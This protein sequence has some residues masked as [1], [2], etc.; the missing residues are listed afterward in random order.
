[1]KFRLTLGLSVIC[2]TAASASSQSI[3]KLRSAYSGKLVW[4]ESSA[5]VRFT[6]SG[7]V[8]FTDAGKLSFIWKI[9]PEVKQ[10]QIAKGVTVN[11]AFHSEASVKIT[12]E[13]RKTSVVYG[14]PEQAWSKNR[15]VKAFTICTFQ[16]F[17]GVMTLSNLTSQDPRGFHVRGWDNVV[18]V[19]ACDFLDTRDGHGNNSDGFEGGDGSTVHD[20]YFES[21]DDIIKVYHDVTVT[22]T[23]IKMVTNTVPIQLGWGD[24]S[25][26]AVGTFRNLR[27]LGEGGRGAEENAII[28]G[29]QGRY[30]VTVNIDGCNIENPNATLVSLRED[31]MT[32][33]GEITNAHI[34]L[35]SYA[36]KYQK[37]TNLLTVCGTREPKPIY[38]CGGLSK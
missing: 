5:T 24:Y 21:G 26:G 25:D 2:L 37:G 19:S 31:T 3:D 22:D 12:G 29:R 11:A 33:R 34:K 18:H 10:I 4:D 6:E 27:I 9:P 13:D 23:T 17:G 36:G 28:S 8:E 16:N 20:C 32:L 30:G 14:T 38:E 7:S 35:K 15:D 1:M